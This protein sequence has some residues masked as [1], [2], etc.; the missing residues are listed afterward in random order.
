MP[1]SGKLRRKPMPDEILSNGMSLDDKIEILLDFMELPKSKWGMMEPKMFDMAWPLLSH[2]AGEGFRS[3]DDELMFWYPKDSP[4]IDA[5]P[6]NRRF[7]TCST[8]GDLYNM[9]ENEWGL[10]L[11][12]IQSVGA[13]HVRGLVSVT[14]PYMVRSN[15][16]RIIRK[17]LSD[18]RIV[19]STFVGDDLIWGYVNK[20]WRMIDS[21]WKENPRNKE[22]LVEEDRRIRVLIGLQVKIHT[23]WRV[24]FK[25]LDGAMGITFPTDAIGAMEAFRLRDIPPGRTRRA[26]LKHWVRDHYRKRRV[27]DLDKAIYV[28][29]HIRGAEQFTWNGLGCKILPAQAD[30]DRI[31]LTR[32]R[33]P[34]K[35]VAARKVEQMVPREPFPEQPTISFDEE[36]YIPPRPVQRQRLR[37]ALRFL[38][39]WFV[40]LAKR[41]FKN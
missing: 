5:L 3:D 35:K 37:D 9:K 24:Y 7:F 1:R 12:V 21:R 17:K 25:D 36:I 26:A 22:F 34:S 14:P 30:I 32:K 18:D 15:I 33:R 27:E 8:I 29:E 40:K 19:A 10:G 28:C 38:V 20:K 41:N 6:A 23:M 31:A 2:L 4:G 13:Q 16:G 39:E 11:S